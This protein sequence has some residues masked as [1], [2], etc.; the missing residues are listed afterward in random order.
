MGL[1]PEIVKKGTIDCDMVETTPVVYKERLIRF[2]Y[3]RENY[4]GN[5]TGRSYFRF[6]DPASGEVLTRFAPGYH[7]GCAFVEG[8]ML[9]AYGTNEPGGSEIRVFWSRD[10]SK[11]DSVTALELGDKEVY[12]TS[13]CKSGNR[14][15]MALE[16]GGPAELVGSRF[17]IFF[18]QSQNLR[19][20]EMMPFN[21]VFS[22]EKYTACPALRFFDENYYMV[23]LESKPGPRYEPHVIRSRDLSSWEE[24]SLGPFLSPSPGDKRI[25]NSSLSSGLREKIENAVN[26]NNSDVDFCE[27]EGETVINYSWGN[28][29][30][31]EFLAEASYEGTPRELI[32]GF[33]S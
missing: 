7:F 24:S 15:V 31:T 19:E 25:A 13:V 21:H 27:H 2:E 11:W 1:K 18:A 30:G 33:F 29:K 8:P 4:Y 32:T 6:L 22:R 16:L 28:Q 3:V 9:F 23:Y 12:N 17:T 20:W 26:I 5:H 10:L 14:Y